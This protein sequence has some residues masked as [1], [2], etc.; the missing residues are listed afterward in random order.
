MYSN[1]QYGIKESCMNIFKRILPVVLLLVMTVSG[2]D[3]MAQETSKN[4]SVGKKASGK[5]SFLETQKAVRETLD[6]MVEAY[7]GKNARQFMSFVAENYMGDDSLLER[8]IRRDFSKFL[9]MDI[10]YTLNNVTTD[11]RNENISVAVSFTRS[12]TDVKTTKR[13][14]KNGSAAFIF[15][16]VDGSPKLL[17]MK[18]PSMFGV[19]K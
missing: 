19:G 9:D 15:R 10:R 7:T 11:S 16:M 17:D 1:D 6:G 18:R 3:A 12:Y 14:N 13:I 4:L 5:T 8:R 2:A